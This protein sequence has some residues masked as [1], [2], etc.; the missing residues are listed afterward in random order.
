MNDSD[1]AH[2]RFPNS[3]RFCLGSLTSE[4]V[5]FTFLCAGLYIEQT[6]ARSNQ[7][8]NIYIHLF[9][10]ALR[11]VSKLTPRTAS[12][13]VV[14]KMKGFELQFGLIVLIA[15]LWSSGLGCH[16]GKEDL[17]CIVDYLFSMTCCWSHKVSRSAPLCEVWVDDPDA[18]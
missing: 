9:K 13:S 14:K 15:S 4:C 10:A 16:S 6:S 17:K 1:V 3:Q 7:R 18:E 5:I 8:K 12:Q 11:H 2:P